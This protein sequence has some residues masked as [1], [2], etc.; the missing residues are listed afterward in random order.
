MVFRNIFHLWLTKV[1]EQSIRTPDS[2]R[3]DKRN[4][5][6]SWY[7]IKILSII[8]PSEPYFTKENV[9][10]TRHMISFLFLYTTDT[11]QD[12]TS[13]FAASF[14]TNEHRFW[15]TMT[16]LQ[17]LWLVCCATVVSHT[18]TT[19]KILYGIQRN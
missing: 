8:F 4:K 1:A 10:K 11:L 6:K 14:T 17:I 12:S 19:L 2:R 3:K 16:L 9:F 18:Y 13:Q 7:G 15:H 5:V